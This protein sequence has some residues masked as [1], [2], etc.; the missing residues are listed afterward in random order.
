MMLNSLGAENLAATEFI[1]RDMSWKDRSPYLKVEALIG[2]K[3]SGIVQS[4][5]LSPGSFL[6][7]EVLAEGQPAAGTY[8]S[9]YAR[10]QE[11]QA[12]FLQEPCPD[13]RLIT[14]GKQC[15]ACLGRDQFAPIHR[16]HLGSSMTPAALTYVNLDHFL[17][18]AT[19]PDGSSKVGTASLLSNPRRL[20]DQAV[21]LATFI[22]RADSGIIVRQLEDLVSREAHLT[23]V[24]RASAKYKGWLNP[25]SAQR[26]KTEHHIAL[27]NATWALEDA[28]DELEGFTITADS[29]LPSPPM[30]RAYAALRA[31]NPEPLAPYPSLTE[32][33][34]GFYIS[35]GTG[36]FLTAHFGDPDQ[37]FLLNTAELSNRA[38]RLHGEL[39]PPASVQ[40]SLF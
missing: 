31:E 26:L 25:L 22:A 4:L 16:V 18:V 9:G 24:K 37:S 39:T 30:G 2:G 27:E 12:G 8:C 34:H 21:A 1:W 15:P 11:D 33:P 5:P 29:W 3:P 28:Q 10:A 32:G 20:D 13:S 40:E 7:F 6:G 23:Q 14:K 38:C 35:G 36:K 19:F 17:Y